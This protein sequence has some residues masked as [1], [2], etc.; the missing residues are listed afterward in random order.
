M[1]PIH[2]TV[3]MRNPAESEGAGTGYSWSTRARPIAS[4]QDST[5]AYQT[6]KRLPAGRLTWMAPRG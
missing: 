3:A 2:V 5:R 1:G 4:S 6:L